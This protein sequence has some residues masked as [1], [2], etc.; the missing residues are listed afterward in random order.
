MLLLAPASH[1][2]P[3]DKGGGA[4]DAYMQPLLQMNC[5]E[6]INRTLNPNAHDVPQGRAH[7][8]PI[9]RGPDFLHIDEQ[10]IEMQKN[11][12][13]SLTICWVSFK[14]DNIFLPPIL[15]N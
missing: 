1:G 2:Q 4:Y 10:K 7:Q 14:T 13:K 8:P 5:L 9:P 3:R 11:K 15:V 12:R 6:E